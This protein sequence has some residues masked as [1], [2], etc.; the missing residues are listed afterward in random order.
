CGTP[1]VA[2][3]ISSLPEVVGDAAMLVNPENVFEIERGMRDVLLND[4]LRAQLIA[5]GYQQA[6]KFS[7]DR[8]ARLVLDTYLEAIRGSA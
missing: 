2:S 8:T 1:V 3:N 5:K 4:G 6:A 7:W